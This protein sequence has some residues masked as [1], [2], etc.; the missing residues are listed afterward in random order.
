MELG[1]LTMTP[2]EQQYLLSKLSEQAKTNMPVYTCL[3]KY[4]LTLE[5]VRLGRMCYPE[6]LF[7][8]TLARIINLLVGINES[9]VEQQQRESIM[10]K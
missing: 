4:E 1:L 3:D 10:N 8:D 6:P 2:C 5:M 7:E 9:L